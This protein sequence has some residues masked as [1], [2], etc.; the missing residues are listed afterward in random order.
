MSFEFFL[1]NDDIMIKPD[2]VSLMMMI[3]GLASAIIS[4]TEN[5]AVDTVFIQRRDGGGQFVVDQNGNPIEIE[6]DD[7]DSSEVTHHLRMAMKGNWASHGVENAM[8]PM[9]ALIYSYLETDLKFGDKIGVFG[10]MADRELIKLVLLSMTKMQEWKEKVVERNVKL[11][12][13]TFGSATGFRKMNWTQ[14]NEAIIKRY[15]L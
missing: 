6:N 8:I 13:P 3:G 12:G 10:I 1:G 15:S 11:H 5:K 9:A 7:D 2:R 14:H 4:W